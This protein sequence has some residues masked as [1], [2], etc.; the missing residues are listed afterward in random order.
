M[1][2]DQIWDK[3]RHVWQ[4]GAQELRRLE[5]TVDSESLAACVEAIADCSG[6]IVTAGVGTSGA[7][8]KKIAH[9]LSC[10]ERPSFFLDPG[11]APHGALG[12]VQKGD[13]CIL[14]SKGGGTREIVGLIPSLRT[15]GA[16]IIAAGDLAHREG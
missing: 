12:A 5:Q 7:A 14:I 11:D 10:I 8:A 15:K 9:S 6:R 13:V 4:V 3:A 16:T 2:K 1:T